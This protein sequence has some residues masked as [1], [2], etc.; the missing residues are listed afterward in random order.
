M[1]SAVSGELNRRYRHILSRDPLEAA[2]VTSA[3]KIPADAVRANLK[4]EN[5]SHRGIREKTALRILV[6]GAVNQDFL[7]E[8]CQLEKLE[9]LELGWPTTA[10][11]LKPITSL[12]SLNVLK[13]NSPRAVTDF[14]PLLQLASLEVLFIENA[15]HMTSLDWLG[16]LAERLTVLGVEGSM[17]TT[18]RIPSLAPLSGFRA[19]ALFLTSTS[20]GDGTLKPLQSM[21][22]LRFLG[23]ARN[24]PRSEF[25]ALQA[26]RPGL[27]CDWFSETMWKL[28]GG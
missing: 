19:E 20:V 5:K 2:Q 21:S 6:A 8:I 11:D 14:T 10:T 22:N 25:A 15:K 13:I 9:H 16:P 23:T 7:E 26:A 4:R 18:Q 12:R 28:T 24:A 17:W 27:V 1:S 3:A